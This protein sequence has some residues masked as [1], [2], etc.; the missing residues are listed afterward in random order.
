MKILLQAFLGAIIVHVLYFVT[1]WA[2]GY[3]KTL[4][5]RPNMAMYWDN[6][7]RLPQEVAFGTT[8][9]P[10]FYLATFLGVMLTWGVVL[11]FYQKMAAN[12]SR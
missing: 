3:V 8:T 9:S 4:T 7:D 2:V 11:F 10:V 12:K 5:H 6:A 1:T